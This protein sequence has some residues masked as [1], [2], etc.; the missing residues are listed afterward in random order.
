MNVGSSKTQI[1]VAV[2][3]A[4]GGAAMMAP[5][6]AAAAKTA[7]KYVAGD[8]HNHTTC[9]DGTIS[10][11]KLVKKSTD[12][13]ANGGATPWGLDWFV[14]A[15]HGNSGG[16][17]NCTLTEDSSLDTP[18]YPFVTGTSP[19]TTWSA[20]IG[21]ANVKGDTS[22]GVG[23]MWRWQSVQ[24]YQYP[25]IEYLNALKG[26]PL[27]IGLESIVAGHEHTSMGVITGQ[28]PASLDT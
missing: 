24:E 9:S 15:G 21:N 7:G 1:A 14:Q 2:M 11:E 6:V 20:S 28:I 3:A 22:A 12:T 4:L 5:M 8:I 18:L 26:L 13:V 19:S 23:F 16:T 27:F 10:M 17:R 25:L